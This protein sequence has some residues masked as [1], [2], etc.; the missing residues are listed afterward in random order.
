MRRDA[1]RRRNQATNPVPPGREDERKDS[2][3]DDA[4][5]TMRADFRGDRHMHGTSAQALEVMIAVQ[6]GL[7]PPVDRDIDDL[8]RIVHAAATPAAGRIFLSLGAETGDAACFLTEVG[9]HLPM[10]R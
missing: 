6:D 7:W 10:S 8:T 4:G 1:T 5:A 3:D 9:E 2:T